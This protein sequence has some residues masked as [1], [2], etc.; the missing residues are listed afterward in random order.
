MADPQLDPTNPQI[1]TNQ[2]LQLMA[3]G[4]VGPDGR[5]DMQA[6]QRQRFFDQLGAF[7]ASMLQSGR[8]SAVPIG[9]GE[10]LGYGLDAAR[11][12]APDTTKQALTMA[13]I[14]KYAQE[15]RASQAKIAA[16]KALLD[17]VSKPEPPLRSRPGSAGVSMLPP[18]P[19][20]DAPPGAPV[21]KRD[22]AEVD[23]YTGTWTPGMRAL[24][25]GV[26]IP[27][28]G[29]KFN[30]RYTPKGGVPFDDYSQHPNIPEPGPQGPSTAAGAF[31]FTGSTWKEVAPDLPDFSPQS[32]VTAFDR[33]AKSEY[34]RKTGR[35]LEADLAAGDTSR[36][37]G[38][39]RGR[40]PTIGSAMMYYPKLLSQYTQAGT[41]VAGGGSAPD[42]TGS[43]LPQLPDTS[44]DGAGSGG[45]P[46]PRI[47]SVADTSLPTPFVD[48]LPERR[49]NQGASPG[50]AGPMDVEARYN[51]AV[52][53]GD[54]VRAQ[55]ILRGE[56]PSDP[57]ASAEKTGYMAEL[58]ASGA[59]GAQGDVGPTG[60]L[61]ASGTDGMQMAQL[62]P[63]DVLRPRAPDVP[64]GPPGAPGYTGG[65]GN[66][67]G[68]G[69]GPAAPQGAPPQRE[70]SAQTPAPGATIEEWA[71]RIARAKRLDALYRASGRTPPADI[72]ELATMDIKDAQKAM[73]A[74]RAY[75][76]AGPT[77]AATEQAKDAAAARAAGYTPGSPEWAAVKRQG[78]PDT[79]NPNVQLEAAAKDAE[80][81]GDTA[82]AARYR[83]AITGGAQ[84]TEQKDYAAYLADT[85]GRGEAPLSFFDWDQARR[86]SGAQNVTTKIEGAGG[87]KMVEAGIKAMDDSFTAEDAA[88][89]RT[90]I[91][92]QMAN[93]LQGFQPGASAEMRM[94][95]TRWLR[96]GGFI[97][98]DGLPDQELFRQAGQRLALLSAPKGQGSVSNYERE[99]YSA[100]L[101]LMT[102]SA[103]SLRKAI[104]IG[105]R[106]DDYDR[107]VAQIHREVARGNGNMPDW[108][109]ARDRISKLGPP[110]SVAETNALESMREQLKAAN[111]GGTAAAAPAG[112]TGAG[113]PAAPPPQ[114][115]T[116]EEAMKLPP[117][118]H[119]IDPNGVR[120]VRP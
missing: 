76:Y 82:A 58:P 119:F 48:G 96:E 9:F 38:A 50:P 21:P 54:M 4:M 60:P 15:A 67:G 22:A 37:V 104:D 101:P 66:F 40:W 52:R 12:A 73:E 112:G 25:R 72:A 92:G 100:A 26:A 8:P 1:D 65:G 95:G 29:G 77:A 32:Q 62:T 59:P 116:P 2:I 94:A 3:P 117:G 71:D 23:Q 63:G 13:E 53:R 68:G 99:L 19:A 56:P 69:P 7:G 10:A 85:R 75:E 31:Q 20:P 111:G 113:A 39:L 79:R 55:Q 108:L 18:P 46:V 34:A 14:I 17:E 118:T 28:S 102:D 44:L 84:T 89:R 64:P 83:Q 41:N 107:Q 109:E 30:V 114:V 49:A 91:Y 24:A 106:L 90:Q 51:D 78:L 97:K 33:L 47:R 5:I 110:L 88:N 81:R 86:K 87:V 42:D 57:A 27:E 61:D 70:L 120:R 35:D 80:S 105:K 115:K 16:D 98:G 6:L 43:R 11:K 36:V 103:E 93:A 74:Q 45:G